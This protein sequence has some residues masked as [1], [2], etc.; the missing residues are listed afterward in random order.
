MK[1]IAQAL[2]YPLL[3]GGATALIFY[4]EARGLVAGTALAW[5]LT[6][7][8]VERLERLLPF[9]P[10]WRPHRGD[11]PLDAAFFVMTGLIGGALQESL[12]ALSRWPALSLWPVAWPLWQQV[13]LG[14]LLQEFTGYWYHRL[15]HERGWLWSIHRPHHTPARLWWMNSARNHPADTALAMLVTL[16]PLVALGA[17]SQLLRPLSGLIGVHLLLQHANIDL[18]L[19]PLRRLI[20]AA[21][22]HR[23]HHSRDR[24]EA[25]HNYGA[26]LLVWDVVF[27]TWYAPP[28]R[29][30]S[31]GIAQ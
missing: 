17:D 7:L 24:A 27:G 31:V 26:V 20:S 22:L 15:Q 28:G 25:D 4:S 19:G 30:A 13:I 11:L 14:L 29:P 2:I 3:M 6:L 1:R 9:E 18:H 10:S 23:W 16:G 5:G 8:A 12:A 21:D